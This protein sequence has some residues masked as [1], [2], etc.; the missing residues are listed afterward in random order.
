MSLL[1]ADFTP[2]GWWRSGHVQTVQASA[3]PPSCIPEPR[4]QAVDTA[5]NDRFHTATWMRRGTDRTA[6]LVPGLASSSDSLP[7]RHLARH[8]LRRRWNVIALDPRGGRGG[9]N[10]QWASY[11]AGATAD[12]AQLVEQTSRTHRHV[13][14]VG[15]SLGA[16]QVGDYLGRCGSSLPEALRRG[17][18]ICPPCDLNEA[19]QV[20]HSPRA[21]LYH[22]VILHE[23]K[24]RM[25]ERVE[26]FP[27]HLRLHEVRAIPTIRRFDELYTAP[28]HGF[29]DVETYYHTQSCQRVLADITHPTLVINAWDDPLLG[30]GCIPLA[31]CRNHPH[32]VGCF[33]RHGGHVGFR[34]QLRDRGDWLGR[35]IGSWLEA[36]EDPEH[37]AQ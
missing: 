18:L 14:V 8:L 6:I 1:Q 31:T 2:H 16:N 10:R 15:I 34:R 27:G 33:P 32:L 9:V 30:A 4:R 13:V 21:R 7:V 25:M 20:L 12:I 36:G 28:A 26:A 29:P 19:A 35:L 23:M 17:V 24:R 3:W 11:H 37:T 5:D 22:D